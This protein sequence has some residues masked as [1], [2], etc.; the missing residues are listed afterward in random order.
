MTREKALTAILICAL[1]DFALRAVPFVLLRGKKR[2]MP[3][4]LL[5]LSKVLPQAIMAAMVVYC[6]RGA[7]QGSLL[8]G[9]LSTGGIRQMLV[10]AGGVLATAALHLWKR[11]TILSVF[12][13]TMIYMTL[14]AL[15]GIS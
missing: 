3:K 1:L 5:Y 10:L 12:G 15:A 9:G 14:M 8:A 11:N 2:S 7:L 6:L 4:V 13:G